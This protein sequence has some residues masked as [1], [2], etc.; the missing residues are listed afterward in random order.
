MKPLCNQALSAFDCHLVARSISYCWQLQV[1]TTQWFPIH[2]LHFCNIRREKEHSGQKWEKM[3][4]YKY[5]IGMI[6]RLRLSEGYPALNVH[7]FPF[8]H[9]ACQVRATVQLSR[10]SWRTC[11]RP[12]RSWKN[13]E[14]KERRRSD[15]VGNCQPVLTLSAEVAALYSEFMQLI[16]SITSRTLR[17]SFF[18]TFGAV[19]FISCGVNGNMTARKGTCASWGAS[20]D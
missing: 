2:V 8:R 3:L 15:A 6:D 14:R 13:S 7:P 10:K 18:Y 16:K 5:W 17:N 1:E 9:S 11:V 20:C 12:R 19:M 4:R